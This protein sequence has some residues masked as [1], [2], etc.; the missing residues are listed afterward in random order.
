MTYSLHNLQN[1]FPRLFIYATVYVSSPRVPYSYIF[2]FEK[3]SLVYPL[4]KRKHHLDVLF[5]FR[6]IVVLNPALPSWKI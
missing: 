5:L 1:F 6:F 3:L 4:L 2:A